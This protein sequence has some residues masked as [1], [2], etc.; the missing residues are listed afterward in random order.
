LKISF[1]VIAHDTEQH[2]GFGSALPYEQSRITSGGNY[3]HFGNY[4]VATIEQ[5]HLSVLQ[6]SSI[7]FGLTKHN[8][9]RTC[10]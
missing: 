2:C 10:I 8:R 5:G 9:K 6:T 3:L 7:E 1:A 4:W